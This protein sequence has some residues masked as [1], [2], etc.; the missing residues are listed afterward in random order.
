MNTVADR[1]SVAAPS[2]SLHDG[3]PTSDRRCGRPWYPRA[4]RA[5]LGHRRGHTYVM[6]IVQGKIYNF[7]ERPTG[8][9]CFVYHF[10]VYVVCVENFVQC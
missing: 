10:T 9:K 7:L 3:K 6:K 8:W 5:G 2:W 4:S 1:V